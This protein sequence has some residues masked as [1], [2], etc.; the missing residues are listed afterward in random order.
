ML[1]NVQVMRELQ[2][3]RCKTL[4]KGRN[5]QKYR[6]IPGRVLALEACAVLQGCVEELE[7]AG[8][9]RPECPPGQGWVGEAAAYESFV[10]LQDELEFQWNFLRQ[11][12]FSSLLP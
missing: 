1:S 7:A 11:S 4:E 6:E 12:D 2:E 10:S 9:A 3:H 5:S 8:E